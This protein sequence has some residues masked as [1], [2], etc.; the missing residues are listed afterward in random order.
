MFNPDFII[1]V[2][3]CC[4]RLCGGSVDRNLCVDGELGRFLWQL[5]R[6]VYVPVSVPLQYDHP[7]L[8]TARDRVWKESREC[9]FQALFGQ[10][11]VVD[12]RSQLSEFDRAGQKLC[13]GVVEGTV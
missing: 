10:Y 11:I 9:G 5:M 2:I 8:F 12:A 7:E 13:C 4:P 6:T 1:S 3:K